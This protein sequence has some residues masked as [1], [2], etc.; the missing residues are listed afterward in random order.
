M[1]KG[2][3]TEKSERK[4]RQHAT[5]WKLS[6]PDQEKVSEGIFASEEE[7]L[8]HNLTARK[9]SRFVGS[10]HSVPAHDAHEKE[11]LENLP[12]HFGRI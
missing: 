2:M 1:R 12:P 4:S 3:S 10:A 11:I 5:V 9:L 6:R 7:A 8:A